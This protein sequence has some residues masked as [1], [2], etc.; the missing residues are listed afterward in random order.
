MNQK[1][2]YLHEV[3]SQVLATPEERDRFI[4]DLRTHFTEGESRGDSTVQIID[5]LGSAEAVAA[6]F[7]AERKL[8]YAGFWIRLA[9]FL[10]D[11]SVFILM[12]VPI[13]FL[14]LATEV[15]NV[16]KPIAIP[17][18]ALFALGFIGVALLYFPL[19]EARF[20]KTLGKRFMRIRVIRE[21]GGNISVGQG[22]VRRLA[23]YFELLVPDAIFIPFT[24]KKQRALD[25]LAKTVVIH[26]PGET[27]SPLAWIFCLFGWIAM[28]GLLALIFLPMAA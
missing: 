5:R 4:E 23:L 18:I 12:A 24:D 2:H 21:N 26:E 19:L 13:V 15:A 7:N 14:A 27:A 11:M 9:A 16:P 10:G 25:I 1:E 6:A 22:F 8:E 28:L 17:S 3:R 20:G